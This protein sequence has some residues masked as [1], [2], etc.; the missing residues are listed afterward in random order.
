MCPLGFLIEHLKGG[1]KQEASENTRLLVQFCPFALFTVAI[2][3]FQ[4][5]QVQSVR[6]A[7][8]IPGAQWRLNK[9]SLTHVKYDRTVS[10]C[11]TGMSSLEIQPSAVRCLVAHSSYSKFIFWMTHGEEEERGRKWRQMALCK[12]N[13]EQEE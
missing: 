13:L 10:Y 11:I 3:Y 8:F 12:M 2:Q 5:M 7:E 1:R 6:F 9:C 4:A